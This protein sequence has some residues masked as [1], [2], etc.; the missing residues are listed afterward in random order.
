MSSAL[1]G[2]KVLDLSMNL[3]GPYL[4]W[5]LA[6][7]GARVVKVE[8]PQ[9]GDYARSLGGEEGLGPHYFAAVNRNKQSLAVNL[10]D[11]RGREAFLRLLKSYDVIVEG[12]RP[13]TLERL[14]LGYQELRE[15]EPGLIMVSIT[16]YGH[17]G[18]GRLRAGHD[19]NYLALAGVLGMTGARSGE[20]ALPGVQM[21]DLAGGSLLALAGL[22]AAVIQRSRTGQGQFVD[23]A[24]F[25]GALSLATMVQ[26]G[27]AAG[28]EQAR[29]AGMTLNGRYPCYGVY[30]TKDNGWM[31]LGALEP[32]FWREFCAAVERPDLAARQFGGAEDVEEVA[33]VFAGRTRVQWTELMQAHDAC[34]EPVL[35]LGEALASGLAAARGMVSQGVDGHTRLA[36]P[37]KL[38][39][40]PNP[41]EDPAPALGEHTRQVLAQAGYSPA[42]LEELAAAGVIACARP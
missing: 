37:L 28:L 29:P 9:G 27:V 14:G 1:E 12:F 18:P 22:L 25:D 11:P 7:L 30:R 6:C 4:T 38:S 16:G 40:S 20:L 17:E 3:P 15:R 19:I 34:C 26:A 32:K 5:L 2:L 36:S 8:N 10:K 42:E 39:G 21:A 35:E 33:R 13:G 24:M 41:P 31:S 23:A